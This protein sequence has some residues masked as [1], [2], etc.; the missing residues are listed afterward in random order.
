MN[1]LVVWQMVFVR[2]CTD[3]VEI[4]KSPDYSWKRGYISPLLEHM[5][6]SE[7][8]HRSRFCETPGVVVEV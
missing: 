2:K 7:T 6:L 3:T 4:E 8:Q 5:Y 1:D